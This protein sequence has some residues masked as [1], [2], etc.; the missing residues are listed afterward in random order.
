MVYQGF[1]LSGKLR[2]SVVNSLYYNYE[3][4]HIF[5]HGLLILPR[6]LKR[7]RW[8]QPER[9][10]SLKFVVAQAIQVQCFFFLQDLS[11]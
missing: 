1:G 8:M 4:P 7:Q 6:I 3:T 9:A 5:N 10:L 11:K 2:K